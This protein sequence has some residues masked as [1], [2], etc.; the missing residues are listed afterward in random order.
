MNT[1]EITNTARKIVSELPHE[2]VHDIV[3]EGFGA[4]F[5]IAAD[6]IGANHAD[7]E[8]LADAIEAEAEEA[9]GHLADHGMI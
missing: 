8:A 4:G 9:S 2:I 3:E 1:N 6:E 7:V 5:D